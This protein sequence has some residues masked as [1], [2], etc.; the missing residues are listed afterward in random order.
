MGA[1][2]FMKCNQL[3]LSRSLLVFCED[4]TQSVC[5]RAC[6]GYSTIYSVITLA[7]NIMGDQRGAEVNAIIDELKRRMMQSFSLVYI[8]RSPNE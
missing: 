3:S 1:Q 4:E 6:V 7:I 2:F 8:K 5:L